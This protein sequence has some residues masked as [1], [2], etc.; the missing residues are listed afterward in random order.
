MSDSTKCVAIS[1]GNGT[2]YVLLFVQVDGRHLYQA[3]YEEFASYMLVH[4]FNFGEIRTYLH[5]LREGQVYWDDVA[6]QMR[7]REPDAHAVTEIIEE[8]IK[9][10]VEKCAQRQE[11][12]TFFDPKKAQ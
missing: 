1:P 8:Q 2:Q 5:D 7:L 12:R 3:G 10:A 9:P 4:L 11:L 6:D